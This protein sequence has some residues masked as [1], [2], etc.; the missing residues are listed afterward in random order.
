MKT[1]SRPN[2]QLTSIRRLLAAAKRRAHRVK[3][4]TEERFG[5]FDPLEIVAFRSWGT[6]RRLRVRGR[7]IERKGI[8]SAAR[9]DTFL[10]NAANTLRRIDSDEIPGARLELAFRGRRCEVES[11]SEGYFHAVIESE[12]P[13]EPG[14][15][16]V[17]VTLLDSIA[18]G[19]GLETVAQVLVADPN[20]ELA[21]VSDVDDTV[22]VTGATDRLRMMRIILS[23][24]ARTRVPLPGVGAFYRALSRGRREHPQNAIFYVTRSG[25][26]LYDLFVDFFEEHD[27]P[28]GPLLMRDLALIEMPSD[29][30]PNAAGKREHVRE[31]MRD[32]PE[33]RFVLIGDSGQS[34]PSVYLDCARDDPARVAAIYIREV[35]GHEVDPETCAA[36]E[37]LGVPL[38]VTA[39][40][41]EMA[42]HAAAH[43]FIESG[44][45]AEV[46]AEAELH[47]NRGR[48]TR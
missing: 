6:T 40:T 36:I 34:D 22:I 47:Q 31:I 4:R 21:I 26:N 46:A 19:A 14:W 17:R 32:V 33:P 30:L 2:V 23:A 16:R 41:F 1:A 35:E 45:V 7:V 43:A 24:N 15:H 37:A 48:R 28:R 39:S 11:D 3:L 20:A 5:L 27:I 42:R 44:A 18:G 38:V 10:K 29:A 9:D 12:L 13:L 8:A 25:W